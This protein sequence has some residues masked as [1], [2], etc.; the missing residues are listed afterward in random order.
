MKYIKTYE[1]LTDE[2]KAGDYV[3]CEESSETDSVIEINDF[4]KNNIGVIRSI[5]QFIYDVPYII[6]YDNIPDSLRGIY[7]GF[8]EYNNNRRMSRD[9]IIH[10]SSNKEDLE[11]YIQANKYNL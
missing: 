1:N 11:P 2:P 5:S 3:M 8:P 6:E 9:E 7:L 10:F 4:I